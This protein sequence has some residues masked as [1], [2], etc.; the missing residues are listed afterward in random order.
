MQPRD[1][2]ILKHVGLYRISLRQVLSRLFFQDRSCA[3]VLNRLIRGGHLRPQKGLPGNLS[4]YQL[5]AK[6]ANLVAV[7]LDRA[8]PFGSQALHT[9]LSI[10]WFCCMQG[11]RRYRLER[12]A[13]VKMLGE[14]APPGDHCVEDAQPHPR[15]YRVYAPGPDTALRNAVREVRE[16]MSQART[17]PQVRD[18]LATHRYAFVVLVETPERR[19]ALRDAF[20]STADQH[21]PLAG[22]AYVR[23]E[24]VPGYRTIWEAIR[25]TPE[26]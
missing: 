12:D 15:L 20:R 24:I 25:A 4:H 3:C 7:P 11:A 13:V 16:R 2:A 21:G 10:L 6:G 22:Q 9:H 26:S 1:L 17:R 18:W 5:T 8:T 23:V 14:D 19:A